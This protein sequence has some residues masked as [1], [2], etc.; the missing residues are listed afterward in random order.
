M[1]FSQA[2]SNKLADIITDELNYSEDKRE[3]V[4]YAIET[5]ILFVLGTLLL[6]LAGYCLNALIST[7]TAAFFGGSLRRVSGGAH[8]NTPQKCL[9]FGTLVYSIMGVIAE[10]LLTNEFF[11]KNVLLFCILISFI[12]VAY[13]APVDSEAKPIHSRSLKVRLK[14]LSIAF[15]IFTFFFVIF[16]DYKLLSISAVF[17]VFYQSIT[18]L[19]IFNSKGVNNI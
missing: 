15:V 8:F 1:N 7:I 17:G 9:A 4:A 13:L 14:I 12:L 3:V 18:L 6:I 16:S 19:P 11:N 10:K 2:I 5:M